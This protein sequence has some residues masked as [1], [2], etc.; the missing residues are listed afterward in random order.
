MRTQQENSLTNDTERKLALIS[1]GLLTLLAVRQRSWPRLMLG[2]VGADL[3][4]RGLTGESLLHKIGIDGNARELLDSATIA[5]S[6]ARGEIQHHID[7][8]EVDPARL[9][10]VEQRLADIY[11]IDRKSVV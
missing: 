1:G 5:L 10:E 4:V 8:V 7:S 11:E 9:A 6:E 2:T 3:L